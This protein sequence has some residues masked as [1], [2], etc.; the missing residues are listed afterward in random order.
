MAP[1][2]PN[3]ITVLLRN[4]FHY[5]GVRTS[6]KQYPLSR[7]TGIQPQEAP[8]ECVVLFEWDIRLT[9]LK[10]DVHPEVPNSVTSE[11]T[12][13]PDWFSSGEL[14][15]RNLLT[16]MGISQAQWPACLQTP[17]G[18]DPTRRFVI[19]RVSSTMTTT[20]E[21]R[22]SQLV[23]TFH[24]DTDDERGYQKFVK[25][26]EQAGEKGLP[27]PSPPIHVSTYHSGKLD[28]L[29]QIK[30]DLR[31]ME[32]M[33]P[34]DGYAALDLGNTST[35]LV[36]FPRNTS[37]TEDTE[38]IRGEGTKSPE[39][40]QSTIRITKYE[41]K[42]HQPQKKGGVAARI[43][44]ADA[45]PMPFAECV[46]GDEALEE[47]SG[48]L[49]MGAKRL[50][51]SPNPDEKQQILL[52]DDRLVSIP[53][54]QPAEF[55]ISQLIRRFHQKKLKH[56]SK[57]AITYPTTFSSREVA[58]LK[59]SV[60]F[61]WVRSLGG[62]TYDLGRDALKKRLPVVIDEASAAVFF[63]LF[64]DFIQGPGGL[65]SFR[66][67]YPEGVNVL[68]YDC[69]GGTTDV[70]VVRA[71]PRDLKLVEIEVL[72]RTGQRGFGGD[73]ITAAVFRLLKA[74]IA[75]KLGEI[76][77]DPNRLEFPDNVR[78]VPRF[79]DT[80]GPTIERWVPIKFT[81]GS[82]DEEIERRRMEATLE[83]WRWAEI[84]KQLL[85]SPEAEVQY[86]YF[87]TAKLPNLL[88][89][90]H[91][92]LD[93]D[94]C[95]RD[96]LDEITLSAVEV[97]ELIKDTIKSG[98]DKV[99]HLIESRVGANDEIHRV[100]VIGNASRYPLIREMLDKHLLV[101]FLSGSED[102]PGRLHFDE[103]NL[104]SAVAKGAVIAHSLQDTG[105]GFHVKFDDHLI[106]RLPFDLTYLDL[107]DGI[108]REIYKEHESYRVLEQEV[109]EIK[110]PN[111]RET[112]VEAGS[113]V[114]LRRRWP[115][116][117]KP[118]PFLEFQFPQGVV[119]P[120]ELTYR[121]G[122]R[123]RERPNFVMTDKGARGASTVQGME[124]LEASYVSPPQYGDLEEW[125]QKWGRNG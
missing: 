26:R 68:L 19:G 40:T 36:C 88:C 110:V 59:E 39:S 10:L 3:E 58:Q 81:Q 90:A 31:P 16:E 112:G 124:H 18:Q 97:D 76:L 50:L 47:F 107:A 95:A 4:I 87:P 1:N 48:G 70:A 72:G 91:P 117:T 83:M 34:Y 98:I 11:A 21:P 80:Q 77:H 64:R 93:R 65:R 55:F 2:D 108:E 9:F 54:Q 45:P 6:L 84:Y 46:V 17:E 122:D 5:T 43:A 86:A 66:Y 82:V 89:E 27:I 69:G 35:T 116:E 42:E 52:D 22:E 99:N 123:K 125:W 53:K 74:K 115:G 73:N 44:E 109:R 33:K 32:Q 15:G 71:I 30:L 63:F 49:V 114:T 100:Y 51:A 94:D 8:P 118:E 23:L 37:R 113:L 67:L 104:K 105:F 61:A 41:T 103:L 62:K 121:S 7:L 14:F 38:V 57:L 75:C 78:D 60:Y 92:E 24:I 28:A 79:L 20:P 13:V 119:G 111:S 12:P 96:V 25:I 106:D 56:L 101:Q 85:D 120:L 29:R 102:N